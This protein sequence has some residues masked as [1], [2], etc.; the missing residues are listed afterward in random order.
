MQTNSRG[1]GASATL[2]CY[3]VKQGVVYCVSQSVQ[4][5]H[6][7]KLEFLDRIS[8]EERR[9]TTLITAAKETRL[10]KRGADAGADPGF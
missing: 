3:G 4:P 2:E 8:G 6:P 10:Y 7:N 9:V 1:S 5:F